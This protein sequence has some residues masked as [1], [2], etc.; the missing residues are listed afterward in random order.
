[1]LL[2]TKL[3]MSDG[4]QVLWGNLYLILKPVMYKFLKT[5]NNEIHTF[6]HVHDSD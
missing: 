4:N 2:K 6:G 3:T 5:R 1:M